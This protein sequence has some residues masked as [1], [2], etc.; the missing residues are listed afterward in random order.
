MPTKQ[1][2]CIVLISINTLLAVLFFLLTIFLQNEFLIPC[3]S[4]VY[5]V[6]IFIPAAIMLRLK[7]RKYNAL[8]NEI[9]HDLLAGKDFE[10]I[11]SCCRDVQNKRE[12]LIRLMTKKENLIFDEKMMNKIQ[13][14]LTQ[15]MNALPDEMFKSLYREL[16]SYKQNL[17]CYFYAFWLSYS[18]TNYSFDENKLLLFCLFRND[19]NENFKMNFLKRFIQKNE[20]VIK[21][22]SFYTQGETALT[23]VTSY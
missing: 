14:L 16:T 10:E 6:L 19:E 7:K 11:K 2:C 20:S 17:F 1:N 22:S 4:F 12:N 18:T 13:M 3:A 21:S 8:N 15:D 5:L 9:E 23:A